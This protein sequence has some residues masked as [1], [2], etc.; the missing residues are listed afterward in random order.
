MSEAEAQKALEAPVLTE[1]S[2]KESQA[3]LAEFK[4]AATKE[5]SL[6]NYAVAADWYSKA[7]ELQMLLNG[8][9]SPDNADLLY[10]YGRCLYHVAISKSDVLGSKVA[11]S[12][13][14][15][16]KKKRK[17]ETVSEDVTK[18]GEE[19]LAEDVV[20]AVVEEQRWHEPIKP[21]LMSISSGSC[22]KA[23]PP[24]AHAARWPARSTSS[25]AAGPAK[26][27]STLS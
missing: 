3:Q 8:E 19:K 15:P 23:T 13:E 9:M 27:S 12:G 24:W 21:I 5:Y 14:E 11:G 22:C 18:T 2:R 25:S 6:K 26:V 20:G 17:T 16:K 7:S 1:E 4:A 10:A